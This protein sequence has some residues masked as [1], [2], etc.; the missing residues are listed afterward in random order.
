M[1]LSLAMSAVKSE[2]PRSGESPNT[3]LNSASGL[4]V[5]PLSVLFLSLFRFF[6]ASRLVQRS[7]S[8]LQ[9]CSCTS[10]G[11]PSQPNQHYSPSH[12]LQLSLFSLLL[13]SSSW[14]HGFSLLYFSVCS[15]LTPSHSLLPSPLLLHSLGSC[16]PPPLTLQRQHGRRHQGA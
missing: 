11:Q 13:D 1:R 2:S 5:T 12:T 7:C 8:R 10:P 3:Q 9:V 4:L 16:K 15:L 14:L 6:G